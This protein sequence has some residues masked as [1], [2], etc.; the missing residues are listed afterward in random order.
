MMNSLTMIPPHLADSS[1]TVYY[2]PGNNSGDI[3][4]LS[5][6]PTNML[7]VAK[8]SANAMISHE[9]LP[10]HHAQFEYAR[11]LSLPDYRKTAWFNCFIEGWA[12]YVEDLAEE[13]GL[14]NNHEQLKGKLLQ[15][16]FRAARLV[17]DT[18]L[19]FYGWTKKDVID[20][21]HLNTHLSKVQAEHEIN[22]YIECPAQAL[23]YA[24][25]KFHLKTLRQQC[26]LS[27]R[28]DF[29]YKDFHE[30]LLKH[31]VAP[32]HAIKKSVLKESYSSESQR[33]KN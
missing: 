30:R 13:L 4:T 26:I 9:T 11:K 1:L 31:G 28:G 25:G 10:G 16:L 22:R 2:M 8:G 3:G 19:H 18:G 33:K 24:T 6:N 5:T 17:V 14:Y 32:L 29:N 12:L 21:L 23:S 27:E 20:Y 15:E 7:G